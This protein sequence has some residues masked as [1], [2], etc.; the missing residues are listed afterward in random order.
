MEQ[1]YETNPNLIK[2]K[3]W[4]VT[5]RRQN[6]SSLCRLEPLL[7][8]LKVLGSRG[9]GEVLFSFQYL[10]QD[11]HKVKCRFCLSSSVPRRE[12]LCKWTWRI[13]NHIAKVN[14]IMRRPPQVL[15]EP[16]AV[17]KKKIIV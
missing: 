5:V 13:S 6:V 10:K 14:P 16:D 3:K 4:K 9:N 7:I 2:A 17:K 11:V 1:H 15:S 12:K 8:N